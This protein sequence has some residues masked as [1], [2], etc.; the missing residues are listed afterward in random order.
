M[1]KKIKK[2]Y[3]S[4]Y[5]RILTVDPGL[6]GTGWAYWDNFSSKVK[7]FIPPSNWGI[8]NCDKGS[9]QERSIKIA[10]QFRSVLI[11]T[12]ANYIIIEMPELWQTGKS[13]ASA[14]SGDLHKLI[15]LIGQLSIFSHNMHGAPRLI[16]PREWK[17]QLDKPTV[18]HRIKKLL[19]LNINSHA[20]DAVG[21]GLSLQGV[22]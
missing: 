15:Y 5:T 18:I 21:M 6:G 12:G 20:A 3:S 19:G 17:G 13:M 7:P 9:W 11:E 10:Y 22:L 4:Q 8:L 2:S 1:V 14:T 16:L